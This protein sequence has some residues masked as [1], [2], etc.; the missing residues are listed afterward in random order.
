MPYPDI[1]HEEMARRALD[2]KA[3]F[4]NGQTKNED[5][6]RDAL[7][8]VNVLGMVKASDD[9]IVLIT[10]DHDFVDKEGKLYP[11]LVEELQNASFH[12]T[13]LKFIPV[14]GHLLTDTSLL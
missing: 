5:A 4:P 11:E 13:V 10:N 2:R 6:Y 8:W 1:P 14:S 12:R 3:P 7:I 9:P